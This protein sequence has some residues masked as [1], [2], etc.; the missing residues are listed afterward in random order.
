VVIVEM[1]VTTSGKRCASYASRATV[2]VDPVIT[3]WDT[4]SAFI[5]GPD[6]ILV[7]LYRPLP[8]TAGVPPNWGI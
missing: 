3:D 6:G 7:E 1:M 2:L 5:A 8:E 4:E